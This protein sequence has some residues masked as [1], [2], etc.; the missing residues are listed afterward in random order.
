[1]AVELINNA[2]ERDWTF[3][4]YTQ[5]ATCP[6]NWTGSTLEWIGIGL[7]ATP[8]Q[9]CPSLNGGSTG[10]RSLSYSNLPDLR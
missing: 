1:M 8:A 3:Q 9:G 10:D 6:L 7:A 4:D 2:D 5:A